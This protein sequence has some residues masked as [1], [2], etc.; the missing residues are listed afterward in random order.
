M[1]LNRHGATPPEFSRPFVE[2]RRQAESLGYTTTAT[3]TVGEGRGRGART[4]EIPFN[5]QRGR[6]Q[7]PSFGCAGCAPVWKA[8]SGKLARFATDRHASRNPTCFLSTLAR[9]AFIL[10]RTIF[11][12]PPPPLLSFH[13]Q[14]VP[15][16]PFS[17][18]LGDIAFPDLF[19]LYGSFKAEIPSNCQSFIEATAYC[20]IAAAASSDFRWF[21]L[22][23]Q[24]NVFTYA[25]RSRKQD[26]TRRD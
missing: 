17:T 23:S 2:E 7:Q 26:I 19:R 12:S 11:L 15:S 4:R 3:A 14:P 22:I 20:G 16:R 24:R 10:S 13:L 5:F 1:R 8:N 18:P 21:D 9:F 6:H 25:F